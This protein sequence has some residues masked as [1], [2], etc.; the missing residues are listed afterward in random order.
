MSVEERRK[1]ERAKVSVIKGQVKVPGQIFLTMYICCSGKGRKIS[2]LKLNKMCCGWLGLI[3]GGWM[4][5]LTG[6][7]PLCFV[8]VPGQ[9]FQQLTNTN[10]GETHLV[11]GDSEF[12]KR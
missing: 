10:W 4:E 9:A 2:F 5:H 8:F 6:G 1:K 3:I 11:R 7:L 12:K